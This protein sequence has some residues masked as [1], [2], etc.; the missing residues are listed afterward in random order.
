MALAIAVLFTA[1]QCTT[2]DSDPTAEEQKR[3]DDAA[4]FSSLNDNLT[5]NS[6]GDYLYD[7]TPLQTADDVN[8]MPAYQDVNLN[9]SDYAILSAGYDA[10]RSLY[11]LNPNEQFT[12]I[13]S[14]PDPITAPNQIAATTFGGKYNER[15]LE[16]GTFTPIRSGA[17]VLEYNPDAATLESIYGPE[18]SYAWDNAS[19]TLTG[20]NET[21]GTA[22]ITTQ[23]EE[24]PTQTLGN[25]QTSAQEGKTFGTF[26]GIKE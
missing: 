2:Y 21:Q 11:F 17:I 14:V 12:D 4:D 26:W 15:T 9:G 19:Q 22:I 24:N 20:T 7:G 8:G 16:N 10:N 13:G 3:L 1:T 6:N 18:V 5:L 23:T 25:Y